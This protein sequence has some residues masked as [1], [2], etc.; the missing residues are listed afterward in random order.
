MD[1]NI[2][3]HLAFVK[4]VEF[5]SFTRAAEALSYSQSGISRMIGDLESEW[6]LSLLERSRSGV[7]LTADGQALLP[8]AQQLCAAYEAI[9]TEVDRLNGLE[10]GHIRIAAIPA[11]AAHWLPNILREFQRDCPD[12]E[13]ELFQAG[14]TTVE[15]LILEGRADCGFLCL[16]AHPDLDTIFL[17]QNQ[18]LAILPEHHPLAAQTRVPLAALSGPPFLLFK[19]G[20]H[21][22]IA[23][24]FAQKQLPLEVRLETADTQTILSMAEAGLG[25]S[26]LPELLLQNTTYHVSAKSLEPPVYQKLGLALRDRKT[27]SAAVRKF[28]EY[29]PYRTQ[30]EGLRRLPRPLP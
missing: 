7:R 28:L 22:E 10:S 24:L 20:E 4:T 21:S 8:Y 14:S 29:L 12:I 16:P 17:E 26:V 25:V 15:A 9:Q 6:Q 18:L 2:Q 23:E 13:Y 19:S 1:M 5:G 3:K 30:R 11:A 27:A